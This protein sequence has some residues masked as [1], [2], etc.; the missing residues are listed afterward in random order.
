MKKR[1]LL[2]LIAAIC[3]LTLVLALPASAEGEATAAVMG[4]NLAL[5][6]AVDIIYYVDFQNVPGGAEIG[7]L[8][9]RTPQDNYTCGSEDARLSTVGK[10]YGYDK[11]I[12]PG[13][14]SK[15]MTQDI[16]AK[17][18]IKSGDE[19]TYSTLD[20]Y[21]VL[22]YAYN[23]KGNQT[24]LPGGTATLD[25][26]LTDMLNYGATAQKHFGYKT[27]R[28]AN[29]TYYQIKAVGGT[30]PDGT[31]K[32]LFQAG[33]SVTLTA[34]IENFD[35]WENEAGETVGTESTLVVIV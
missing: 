7:V 28:L 16:Y 12:F 25:E 3:L 5:E 26:L 14:S 19:I 30:L 4:H 17:A 22:Q 1:F 8:V 11:F 21:S 15:M 29:A 34:A 18:Y 27:D 6:D 35:H 9:W 13:V 23:M 32:G 10:D 31:I 24:I 2:V 20:K 33:E